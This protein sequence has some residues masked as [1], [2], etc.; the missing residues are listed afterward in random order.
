MKPENICKECGAR[1]Q[2]SQFLSECCNA[3]TRAKNEWDNLPAHV[4]AEKLNE[5]CITIYMLRNDV[6]ALIRG[7]YSC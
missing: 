2:S 5:L 4:L 7:D 1:Q 3:P 6:D